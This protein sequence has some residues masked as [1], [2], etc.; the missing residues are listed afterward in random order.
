MS[1]FYAKG[2]QSIISLYTE[3]RSPNGTKAYILKLGC[4]EADLAFFLETENIQLKSQADNNV[5]P[6]HKRIRLQMYTVLI[7]HPI[8]GL[9]LFEVGPGRK[10]WK[11]KWGTEILDVFCAVDETE[12]TQTLEEAI[13]NV[14]YK[15]GD[16]KHVIVGHLHIDHAGGLEYF[17]G[18]E[19]KI[20]VHEIE[21][22]HAFWGVA[23]KSEWGSYLPYYLSLDLNWITFKDEKVDLFPGISL[24]LAPGHTPGLVMLQLN[25]IEDGTFIFT[26]DHAI[27]KENYENGGRKQGFLLRDHVAWYNSTQLLKRLQAHTNARVVFGHDI[28]TVDHVLSRKS[29]L[30]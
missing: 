15:I 30:S 6:E 25:L 23:T 26:T 16:V 8:E 29:Y 2:S 11:T 7:D 18:T 24:H 9:I 3:N 5:V 20:W 19:T 17:I 13:S 27:I 22:K 12:D 14:G 28:S 1:T 4:L 21:L 10:D